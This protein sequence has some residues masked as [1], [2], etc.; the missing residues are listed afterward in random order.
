MTGCRARVHCRKHTDCHS[1]GHRADIDD[2]LCFG[3]TALQR[4]APCQKIMVWV[5]NRTF[6]GGRKKDNTVAQIK[7][8]FVN[9]LLDLLAAVPCA[10]YVLLWAP[11]EELSTDPGY[12]IS[13]TRR[14]WLSHSGLFFVNALCS[15]NN[16]RRPH[17]LCPSIA[18]ARNRR[19]VIVMP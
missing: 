13:G 8:H 9:L 7:E 1:A 2:W 12:T 4:D 18:T 16:V 10:L 3:P 14:S 15:A 6:Y 5:N 11:N 17:C 19:I